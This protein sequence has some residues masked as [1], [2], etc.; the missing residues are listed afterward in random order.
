MTTALITHSDSQSHVTPDG[1]PERVERLEAIEV[2][3]QDLNLQRVDAPMGKDSHILRAHPQ[4]HIDRIARAGVGALDSDTFLSAGSL[5]AAYRGVG[6]VVKA[7]DMVLN[8]E[9]DNSFCAMRPPGHHAERETP[10]GF[11]LFGNVAIAAKHALEVHGLSR[12]AIM[13]F[14]V[15]HGNG[16]QDLVWNDARILFASTHQMPLYPW[17][18]AASETGAYG[19]ILNCPLDPET[20][21]AAFRKVMEG[22]VLPAIDSFEPE[23]ILISAGFDA[24]RNDPLANLNWVEDDFAWATQRLC[25][26]ADKHCEGRVVSTLE[27]GYDL[28]G[29]AASCAAHV[30]V[31]MERGK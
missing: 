7:V 6:A 15:H 4:T 10:M 24:H 23:L 20:N 19:N 22:Q 12:L 2:A 8:K 28:E 16:T 5:T 11:C 1:H 21:G 30:N 29:L 25:D 17:S 9:V 14:D 26:L 27:G 3:L 13:D 31:L 18:G